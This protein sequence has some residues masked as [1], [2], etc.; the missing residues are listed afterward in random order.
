M[1]GGVNSQNKPFQFHDIV[2]ICC[3]MQCSN[4]RDTIFALISLSPTCGLEPDY[5]LSVEQVFKAFSQWL[6]RHGHVEILLE[7]LGLKP[8]GALEPPGLET[9]DAVNH[10]RLQSWAP[11]LREGFRI[12]KLLVESPHQPFDAWINAMVP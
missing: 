9:G 11:D 2:S 12:P 7:N 10:T 4:S 5:N 1:R 6:V 3:D 8:K